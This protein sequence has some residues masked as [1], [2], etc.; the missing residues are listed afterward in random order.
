MGFEHERRGYFG[1][2]QWQ[3]RSRQKDL[4]QTLDLDKLEH[5]QHHGQQDPLPNKDKHKQSNK[6][7]IRRTYNNNKRKGK[8]FKHCFCERKLPLWIVF[9]AVDRGK[10]WQLL[11]W[12]Y[13]VGQTDTIH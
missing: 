13:S 1:C 3:H 7:S 12:H 6:Q 9:V 2:C 10:L 5:P 11:R 8:D 4:E